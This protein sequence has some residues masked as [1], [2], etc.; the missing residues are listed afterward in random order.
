MRHFE[1]F[2]FR[3]CGLCYYGPFLLESIYKGD[4]FSDFMISFLHTKFPMISIYYK[5]KTFALK[6]IKPFLRHGP[7]EPGYCPD[8]ANGVGA[9]QVAS[10]EAN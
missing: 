7:A 9:D 3:V 4:N 5:S 10:E 2:N 1:Y 8:F 6:G